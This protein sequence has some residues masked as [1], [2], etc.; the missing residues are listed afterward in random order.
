MHSIFV[1]K[2]MDTSRDVRE[3]VAQVFVDGYYDEL[4]YFT[5][6]R[7]KLILAFKNLFN[8]E[9]L[10]LAEMEG[11]IVGMLG[12]SSNRQRAMPV[13]LE[14]LKEAFGA[15]VGEL[16]YQ[17]LKNEFNT[18]LLHDD[19]TGYIE[20]VATLKGARGKGVSTTLMK[21]VMDELPYRR[22]LLEV[23]DA[24]H[25]ARRLYQ[26]MGFRE[27]ERTVEENAEVQG[28]QARIYMEWSRAD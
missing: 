16:A 13:Q 1:T 14:P 11:E 8:A 15:Q 22:F 24:N 5:K 21:Y 23:T 26:K 9:V 18:A 27:I 17:V 3:E 6:D 7:R 20:C 2:M 19:E 4:S 12:C 25:A 28:F 10:Y